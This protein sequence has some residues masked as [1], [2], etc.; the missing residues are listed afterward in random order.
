M[1]VEV[2]FPEVCSLF[3]DGQNARFLE[4][5][6]PEAEFIKTP[7]S[8]TP[9]FADNSPD[10]MLI[11]SMTERT[12]LR[13][14]EKLLPLKSRLEELTDAGVPILATGSGADIFNRRI[15]NLTDKSENE[16]LGLFDLDVRTDL[17]NRYNGKVLGSVDGIALTGFKSQFSFYYGDNSSYAFLSCD[18]GIGI[19]PESRY[20][21]MRRKNLIC[22]Q[23]IGPLLPLNPLFA[24]YLV[25][26]AGV[27]APA[28]FRDAALAA[29]E[30][31]LRE[32]R[33][34]NTRF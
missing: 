34:P 16:A 28:P 6:L 11:G 10:L 2:L 25:S 9:W 1:K 18:R 5:M 32:F 26:L 33:A 27:S 23:L 7:L 19:N 29:Y 24:E 30:Q 22:T 8:G 4:L 12:Q 17:F 31:R 3:G 14:I 21:G 15:I 20:E 13:V